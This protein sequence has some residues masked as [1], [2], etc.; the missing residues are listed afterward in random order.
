MA[1]VARLWNPRG[2]GALRR[3]W[4]SSGDRIEQA[5]VLSLRPGCDGALRARLRIKGQELEHAVST[6]SDVTVRIDDLEL[7]VGVKAVDGERMLV[8]F[9]IPRG[10]MVRVIL[11]AARGLSAQ[12]EP[13]LQDFVF[14][15]E[16]PGA[17]RL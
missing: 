9:G 11:E 5:G 1:N 15:P 13:H 2:N 10:S 17:M 7:F 14:K 3:Y 12:P 6:G 16:A 8:A 4:I